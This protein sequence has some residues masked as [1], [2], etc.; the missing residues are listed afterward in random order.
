MDNYLVLRYLLAMIVLLSAFP[1][2][3]QLISLFTKYADKSQKSKYKNFLRSG[4]LTIIIRITT[5]VIGVAVSMK[6]AGIPNLY[7]LTSMGILGVVIPLALQS[8]L[9][10]AA[11]GLLLVAFDKVRVGD[12]IIVDN[13]VEGSVRD[14]QTFTTDLEH[15]RTNAITEIPNTVMWSKNIQSVYRTKDFKMA[16]KIL[17]SHRNDIKMIERVVK[18]VLLKDERVTSVN[19][20]YTSSDHRGL[21]LDIAVGV[22]PKNYYEL[23]TQLYRNLKIGMQKR[24]VMF[25]DGA[26]PTALSMAS[27][28]QDIYPIIIEDARVKPTSRLLL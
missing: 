3:D 21:K 4:I 25:V 9:S 5:I 17:I 18:E 16:L 7:F 10:D 27:A 26:R 1:V 20:A 24:G 2:S 8:P 14:I 6:I 19:I 28:D 23:K 15:P 11:T 13:D 22:N 12:Y